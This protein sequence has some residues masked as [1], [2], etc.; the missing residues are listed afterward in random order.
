[1]ARILVILS[2]LRNRSSGGLLWTRQWTIGFH[3][4]IG[5]LNDCLL[6]KKH[7]AAWSWCVW[8]DASSCGVFTSGLL[9][10]VLYSNLLASEQQCRRCDTNLSQLW[11]PFSFNLE[12]VW[13]AQWYVFLKKIRD[14]LY[15]VYDSVCRLK[16]VCKIWGFHVGDYDGNH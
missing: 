14:M 13:I 10:L 9:L 1:M 16:K 5:C 7:S 3:K 2:W 6:P 12:L 11:V 8:L 15:I 4:R